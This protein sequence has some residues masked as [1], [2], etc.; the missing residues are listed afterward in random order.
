MDHTLAPQSRSIILPTRM[1]PG[2]KR[3]GL[4]NGA[5][6]SGSSSGAGCT[7]HSGEDA[8]SRVVS[9]NILLG[10]GMFHDSKHNFLQELVLFVFQGM[11]CPALQGSWALT[12][13][14]QVGAAV[15]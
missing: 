2:V 9:T 10:Q 8:S 14:A 13:L 11:S 15:G 7:S 3:Q 1:S 6:G 4:R 5:V 12:Q